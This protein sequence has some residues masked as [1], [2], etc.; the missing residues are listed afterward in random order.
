MPVD[1]QTQLPEIALASH[2]TSLG[3]SERLQLAHR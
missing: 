3:D 2:D 1:R